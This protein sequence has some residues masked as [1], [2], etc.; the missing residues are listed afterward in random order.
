MCVGPDV[1]EDKRATIKRKT[2]LKLLPFMDLLVSYYGEHITKVIIRPDQ[3]YNNL[4]L[5]SSRYLSYK[6]IIDGTKY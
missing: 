6:Q 2:G 4:T 1:L 3:V 5:I